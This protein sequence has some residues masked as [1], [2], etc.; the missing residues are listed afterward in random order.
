MRALYTKTCLPLLIGNARRGEAEI[1]VYTR[2]PRGTLAIGLI[3]HM[4]LFLSLCRARSRITRR[5][6]FVVLCVG[7][8]YVS[9]L[10]AG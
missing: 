7:L 3:E 5:A 1:G 4:H 10:R 8:R 6:S 9:S 2:S